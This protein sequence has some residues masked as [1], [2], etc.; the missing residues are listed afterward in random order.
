M[1]LMLHTGLGDLCRAYFRVR[2]LPWEGEKAALRWLQT[3]DA[4]FLAQLRDCLAASGRPRRLELYASLVAAALA[5][6]GEPWRPGL[7]AGYLD[8]PPESPAQLDTALEFWESLF[9]QTA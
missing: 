8:P 4:P 1:P 5:P 3:H 6:V 9:N 2:G 7:T